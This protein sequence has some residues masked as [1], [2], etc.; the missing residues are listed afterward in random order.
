MTRKR[1]GEMNERDRGM[2]KGREEGRK[3]ERKVFER[4]NN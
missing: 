1:R 4:R 2:H 3:G